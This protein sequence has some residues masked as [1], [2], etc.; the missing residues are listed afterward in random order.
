M[1]QITYPRVLIVNQQSMLKGNA[2]GIT[3][4][5]LWGGWPSKLAFEI[6]TDP[7]RHEH[8]IFKHE[9][10]HQT[11]LQKISR[12]KAANSVNSSVKKSSGDNQGR[13]TIKSTLR[14]GLVMMLDSQSI[15]LSKK[16]WNDIKAFQPQVIYT[17]GASVSVLRLVYLISEKL[18]VPIVIHFMDNWP[19]HL[20]WENNP[21]CKL[22]HNRMVKYLNLCLEKSNVGIAISPIMAREYQ[23]KFEIE[24][25]YLM[26]SVDQKS[27]MCKRINDEMN[28]YVYAGGLHLSRW[29][30]LKDIANAIKCNVNAQLS[31]YTSEQNRKMY[32]EEFKGLPVVFYNYVNHEEIMD[33]YES[34]DVL[35]HAEVD[36]PLLSGFFKYSISTKIPEYL[37]TGKPTLFFGPKSIGLFQYLQENKAAFVAS[38]TEELNGCITQIQNKDFR[39]AIVNNAL[40]LASNN[41]SVQQAQIQLRSLISHACFQS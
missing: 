40:K 1:E 41:H 9:C 37:S 36:N 30:A 25:G 10:I 32:E 18:D 21:L 31:I 11:V 14:Q 38:T 33:V 34:A 6:H 23:K 15:R 4:T 19:E 7:E 16:E 12:S 24:F 35:V 20:Q 29:K 3:L 8:S 17:L 2:T 22:Y 13:S 26:N 5:S 28:N 39:G 27:F